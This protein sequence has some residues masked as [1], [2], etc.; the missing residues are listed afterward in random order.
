MENQYLLDY[1]SF[2]ENWFVAKEKVELSKK[3]RIYRKGIFYAGT[4]DYDVVLKLT[5]NHFNLY[6]FILNP[7]FISSH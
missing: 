1:L 7:D 4:N 3:Y 2:L 5:D 6:T